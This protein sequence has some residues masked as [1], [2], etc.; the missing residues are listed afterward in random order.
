VEIGGP[1][2]IIPKEK[3][4]DKELSE[5]IPWRKER[6][7]QSIPGENKGK[8]NGTRYYVHHQTLLTQLPP[9]HPAKIWAI[10]EIKPPTTFPTPHHLPNNPTLP[11][12]IPLI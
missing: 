7:V 5:C 10:V 2:N 8:K 12:T 6:E 1:A 3:N 11:N 9:S 4:Q